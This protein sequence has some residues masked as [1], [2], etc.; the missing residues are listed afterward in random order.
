MET[1]SSYFKS[2]FNWLLGVFVYT[3]ILL[4]ID[5]FFHFSNFWKL[6]IFILIVII[7]GIA[8]FEENIKSFIATLIILSM[9]VILPDA[10]IK[11]S[12]KK[13]M[14]ES[15]TDVEAIDTSTSFKNYNT[16][17]KYSANNDLMKE[18]R[19]K[20]NVEEKKIVIVGDM[21]WQKEPYTKPNKENELPELYGTQLLWQKANNYCNESTHENFNDWRLP[22]I[23][24]LG[25]FYRSNI[26]VNF[27]KSMT[28]WSS[29]T[30]SNKD[31]EY[32][33]M[34]FNGQT[35]SV[36]GNGGY[37]ICVREL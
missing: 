36:R 17:I 14:I 10:I 22:T 19:N 33:G 6:A 30:S 15:S 34:N 31:Y 11:S 27:D 9:G 26:K 37:A 1:I 23:S 5:Y 4:V 18:F 21:M 32:K 13:Y 12:F 8:S 25:R 3:G 35:Y 29:T 28:F 16:N 20:I 24:E 2:L 7:I